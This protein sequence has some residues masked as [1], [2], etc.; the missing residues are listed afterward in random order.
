MSWSGDDS[1]GEAAANAPQTEEQIIRAQRVARRKRE[2]AAREAKEREQV[3]HKQAEHEKE[4]QERV[5]R[6]RAEY[7]E[8]GLSTRRGSAR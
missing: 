5:E 3:E 6:E 1:D 8:R 4:E 2:D 7:E